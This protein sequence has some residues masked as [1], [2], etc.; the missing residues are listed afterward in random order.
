MRH[1]DYFEVALILLRSGA[2]LEWASL[3]V[4]IVTCP[5]INQ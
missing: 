3:F 1:R 2:L 4:S 5:K